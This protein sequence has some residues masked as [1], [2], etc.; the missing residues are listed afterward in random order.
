MITGGVNCEGGEGGRVMTELCRS[1]LMTMGVMIIIINED[2][3]IMITF[4]K[5]ERV[6]T[7][8]CASQNNG[9]HSQFC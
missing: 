5:E 8:L 6:M 7:G 9:Q 1:L 2:G 3:I 4:G